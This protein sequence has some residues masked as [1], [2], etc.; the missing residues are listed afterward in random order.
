MTRHLLSFSRRQVRR[1]EILDLNQVI[2]RAQPLLRR[3]IGE[4]VTLAV[5]L[6]PALAALRRHEC[7]M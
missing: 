3:L 1:V 6:D 5:T 4:D 2:S 7:C